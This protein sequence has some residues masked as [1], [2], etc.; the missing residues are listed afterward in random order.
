MADECPA[1]TMPAA[2][3]DQRRSRRN[4]TASAPT[5]T[6]TDSTLTSVPYACSVIV[7]FFFMEF[8]ASTTIRRT[9]SRIMGTMNMEVGGRPEARDNATG[10][11]QRASRFFVRAVPDKRAEHGSGPDE[12]C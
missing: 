2:R 4:S 11:R 7:P 3:A 12:Q 8:A 5:V 6:T 1:E 9:A 10:D